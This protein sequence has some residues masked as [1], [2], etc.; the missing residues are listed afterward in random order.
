M[1]WW[2]DMIWY[3]MMIHVSVEDIYTLSAEMTFVYHVTGKVENGVKWVIITPKT[4]VPFILLQSCGFSFD[5]ASVKMTATKKIY[6]VLKYTLTCYVILT[7]IS[8][9]ARTSKTLYG[10]NPSLTTCSPPNNYF[11]QLIDNWSTINCF[12]RLIIRPMHL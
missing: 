2:Y 6:T 7:H 9:W 4:T 11:Q 10:H 1:T 8:V 5:F 3:D 12:R